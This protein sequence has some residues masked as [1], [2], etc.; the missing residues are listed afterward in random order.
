MGRN[1]IEIDFVENKRKRKY[2]FKKRRFAIIKK[3]IELSKLTGCHVEVRVSYD[4]D[5]S[6]VSYNSNGPTAP[7]LTLD[8]L[9]RKCDQYVKFDELKH[10][11]ISILDRMLT[12]TGHIKN[13]EQNIVD[14]LTGFNQ[15]QLLNMNSLKSIDDRSMAKAVFIS[16]KGPSLDA[17]IYKGEQ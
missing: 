9:V 4:E 2:C 16:K 14:M 17:K 1:K 10:N 3:A 13:V 15:I 5:N 8:E 6:L 7:S 11:E 12:N